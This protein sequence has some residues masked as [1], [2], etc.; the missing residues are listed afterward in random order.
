MFQKDSGNYF[1][2][3]QDSTSNKNCPTD[4][5]NTIADVECLEKYEFV[6]EGWIC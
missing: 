4:L 6:Y 1:Y 5:P 3:Q 2:M